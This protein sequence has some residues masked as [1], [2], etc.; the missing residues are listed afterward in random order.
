MWLERIARGEL[1]MYEQRIRPKALPFAD[2]RL[3]R[4]IH[5]DD[6][7]LSHQFKRTGYGVA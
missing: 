7:V 4:E 3:A 5:A 6:V 1:I 2:E